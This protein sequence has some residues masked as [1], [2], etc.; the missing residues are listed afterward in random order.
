MSDLVAT[1]VK[2]GILTIR[3]NRADK[4]NALNLE[5]YD[6]MATAIKDADTNSDVRVIVI[7][8]SGDSFCAGNDLKDF[9]E[10]PP[11]E[12]NS[13]VVNF[14]KAI[15]GAETPIVAA[16]NGTAVGIGTTMLLHCDFVYVSKDATLSL[17]FIN[18]G[19]VPEAASSLLLPRLAGQARAAELLMLGEP[20]SAKEALDI[21]IANAVCEPADLEATAMKT[22]KKLA[23]KPR[24]ALR[25][26]KALLRRDF[27]TVAQRMDAEAKEFKKALASP[28]A[29][30]ALL[31][32]KEKRKPKFN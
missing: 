32:F 24:D 3:M 22:A 27:E 25:R 17:P 19:L 29:K 7:T 10:N 14:L 31:A 12:K 21:G 15:S 18:L 30:E 13:P 28:D 9:T 11:S 20:F 26:T 16:V 6:A 4:K 2:D 5:M 8:G 23:A 1:E